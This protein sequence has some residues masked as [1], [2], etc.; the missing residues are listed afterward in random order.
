LQINDTEILKTLH[1]NGNNP[2]KMNNK[3]FVEKTS[4]IRAQPEHIFKVLTDIEQWNQW[5]KSIIDISFVGSGGLKVGAKIKVLQPQLP[6]A[7]WTITEISKNKSLTWEKR[8]FG[9]KM[10]A[11]HII[12]E[13]NKETIVKLQIIYQ[14][15]MARFFYKLSS[16]LTKRYMTMEIT[17]LKERCEKG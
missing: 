13:S 5:T 10:I 6:P 2:K 8:S 4:V 17:G 15:F 11:N 12:E 7:V 3:Y 1:Q 14:G 16:A 9:L